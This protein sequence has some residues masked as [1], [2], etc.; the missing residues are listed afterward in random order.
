MALILAL[1]TALIVALILA[2]RALIVRPQ[3]ATH[4]HLLVDV[5]GVAE[6]PRVEGEVEVDAGARVV[7]LGHS[8]KHGAEEEDRII[9]REYRRGTSP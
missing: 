1:F 9:P 3:R 5:H 7:G 8:G 4:L 2:L 6:A